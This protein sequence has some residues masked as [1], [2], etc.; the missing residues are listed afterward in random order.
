MVDEL[1][2]N[3]LRAGRRNGRIGG[4][5]GEDPI[6]NWNARG[7]A[8]PGRRNQIGAGRK[9]GVLA[10]R[11]DSGCGHAAAAGHEHRT[12]GHL[13][14]DRPLFAR[15]ARAT[16]MAR[17]MSPHAAGIWGATTPGRGTDRGT[18][19]PHGKRDIPGQHQ[20]GKHEAERRTKHCGMIPYP[21]GWRMPAL[22]HGGTEWP[23]VPSR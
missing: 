6:V 13:A 3:A 21:L 8:R 23:F 1:G 10:H 16:S 2:R 5:G 4:D 7:R 22:N 12:T 15:P 9:R 11:G 17:A 18:G 19:N 20:S 14:R